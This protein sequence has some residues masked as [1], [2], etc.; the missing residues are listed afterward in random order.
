MKPGYF[1]KRKF[2]YAEMNFYLSNP[3]TN[4]N[5]VKYTPNKIQENLCPRF[6]EGVTSLFSLYKLLGHASVSTASKI[7]HLYQPS[8]Q[9]F[10]G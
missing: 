7:L 4:T 1:N 5:Y 9:H 10:L 3:Q 6:S 8:I 2:T